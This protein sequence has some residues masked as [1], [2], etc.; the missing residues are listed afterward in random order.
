MTTITDPRTFYA[1][2]VWPQLPDDL[3]AAFAERYPNARLTAEAGFAPLPDVPVCMVVG[4]TGTGKSTT[5]AKLAEMRSAGH[6]HY[7]EDI[8]DRRELADL[9]IIPTAQVMGGEPVR[10]I[11]DREQRFELTRR[12]AQQ[13]E[14][15]GSA[16]VY[17]WLYYRWD[18]R[19]P[20]LS[21]GLRGPGEI[22]YALAH[23]PRWQVCELW[24]DPVARL[25]R[26]SHRED[27]FDFLAN[28]S[29]VEDLRFL[30][31]G[32]RLEVM[33]LLESGEITAKAVI[34]A[35]AES[36]NYGGDAY[37]PHNRTPRYRCLQMDNMTPAD[38]A[39][40]VADF[41]QKGQ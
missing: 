40:V 7:C 41:I 38:V 31:E 29:A 36:H 16:A 34:T 28:S 18:G 15:G 27:R 5:L 21:D 3:K 32:R 4:L 19:T 33:H 26:L 14:S 20:L 12:F 25:R 8:P 17:G 37:D 35:R 22:A 24:V 23:Y 6:L 1:E 13:F 10:P 11:K 39:Q 9:V 2:N 30:P